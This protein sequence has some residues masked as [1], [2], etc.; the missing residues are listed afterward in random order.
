[1]THHGLKPHADL[2]CALRLGL[3]AAVVLVTGLLPQP[4]AA[5]DDIERYQDRLDQIERETRLEVDTALPVDQRMQFDYG[6]FLSFNFLAID[7]IDQETHILR[8]TNL[9]GFARLN[10]DDVHHFFLR[11]RTTYN[12]FNTNDDFSVHGDDYV[13][14]TLDRGYY[15]LDLGRAADAYGEGR[16]FD[17]TFK[18]GRQRVHLANGLALSEVLDGGVVTLGNE[19]L[20]L[21]TFAGMTRRSAVDFDSSRPNFSGDTER[22]FGGGQIT[23]LASARHRP[24]LYGFAQEDRNDSIVSSA[25]DTTTQFHYDSY[26]IG[27][28]SE[29]SLGDRLVYGAELVYQGGRGL[30]SS[31]DADFD[32]TTQE[33]E[34][35]SAF[36]ADLR[37]DYTFQGPHRLRLGGELLYA[38]GDVDRLHTNNTLG[39]N[40]AE[41]DDHAFNAFGFINTGLSFSPDPSNLLMA[42]TSIS[43]YPLPGKGIFSRLQVGADLFVYGK[44]NRHAPIEE[45][46]GDHNYLGLETDFFANWQMTSDLA[47]NFRYG[48]FFPGSA[49]ETDHDARHFFFSGVTLAF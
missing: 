11:G 43:A 49:I 15:Q 45:T 8:Q 23:W 46:T 22:F 26:Y 44:P 14:P 18:G 17:L 6:G 38:T 35:I 7:D 20:Q 4:T 25:A 2:R 37:L 47:F 10:I 3:I 48:V 13:E 21:M 42:R 27:L 31:V 9:T 41:T 19:D 34:E 5:Q 32:S 28:G 30:S 24:F 39:G 40:Q 1:M 33:R 16:K 29:G 36:A 12:D